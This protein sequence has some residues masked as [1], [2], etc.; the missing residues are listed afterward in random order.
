VAALGASF[1]GA[2][3]VAFACAGVAIGL[4]SVV[5]DLTV[6][7]FK[8]SAGLKDSGRILPGHG[9]VMDRIDSL[10]AALPLFVLILSASGMLIGAAVS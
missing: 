4:L 8:R 2:S 9:G 1:A 3:V 6:S 5:G 7:Q 10:V